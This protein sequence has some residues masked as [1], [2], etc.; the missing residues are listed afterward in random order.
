MEAREE[1]PPRGAKPLCWLL[2]TTLRVETIDEAFTVLR[3]YAYRWRIERFHY[4]LKSG[5]R[6]ERHQLAPESAWN[7]SWP[8]CR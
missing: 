4:V 1:N 8:R 3:W 2:A 5:C 7:D 6:I